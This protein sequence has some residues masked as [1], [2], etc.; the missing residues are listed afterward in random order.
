MKVHLHHLHL[1]HSGRD[2]TGLGTGERTDA[3]LSARE[4]IKIAKPYH[5]FYLLWP[6]FIEVY[7]SH[8]RNVGGSTFCYTGT[9]DPARLPAQVAG[10]TVR[11]IPKCSFSN[12]LCRIMPKKKTFVI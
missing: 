6:T 10:C 3:T 4:L 12:I 2:V 11:L 5:S 8:N 9:G 1:H 7:Y